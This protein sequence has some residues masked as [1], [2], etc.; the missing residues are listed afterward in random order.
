MFDKNKAKIKKP[1]NDRNFPAQTVITDIQGPWSVS[2]DPKW[3][4]PEQVTFATLQDWTKHPK[5]GI[6]YY[7]GIATYTKTFDLPQNILKE[8]QD[9]FL[10]LGEV[11]NMA[12]VR[13]NG[14]DLG[15]I[16]TAPWHVNITK[17]VKQKDNNLEIDIANL[18]PNRLIGDEQKPN[19]GVVNRQWPQWLLDGTPRTSGRYTF[20]TH[21]YYKADSPLLKSG[22]LGPLKIVAIP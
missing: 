2:F 15:V 17:A 22:L 16:W 19:D 7:S 8:N 18:W 4:G 5:E 14:Q 12:R 13:L 11:N 1:E 20:T 21:Q 6:K 3:G 10:N 9:I